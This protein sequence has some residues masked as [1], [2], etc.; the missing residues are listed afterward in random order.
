MINMINLVFK[1]NPELFEHVNKPPVMTS[2]I[3]DY[4]GYSSYSEDNSYNSIR[5]NLISKSIDKTTREWI[6]ENQNKSI[7]VQDSGNMFYK[8]YFLGLVYLYKTKDLIN[9]YKNVRSHL[10]RLN[11]GLSSTLNNYKYKYTNKK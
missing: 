9:E 3:T 8:D 6:R 1:K 2:P 7:K 5:S 10:A 11:I 4:I